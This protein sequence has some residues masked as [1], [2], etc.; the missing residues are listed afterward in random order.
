MAEEV[1]ELTKKLAE[2]WEVP[3]PKSWR[4]VA[5]IFGLSEEEARRRRIDWDEAWA[6]K[7]R[8]LLPE[9]LRYS[10]LEPHLKELSP[11]EVGA[12]MEFFNPKTRMMILKKRG[13]LGDKLAREILETFL[14]GDPT[15]PSGTVAN[16]GFIEWWRSI[17]EDPWE[18]LREL[19]YTPKEIEEK[20]G[21]K[22]KA[23]E[24]LEVERVK[25]EELE[26]KLEEIKK[27]ERM[28]KE[29]EEKIRMLK[30]EAGLE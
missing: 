8:N 2:W 29:L 30:K 26:P 1:S 11:E 7:V 25:R 28:K 4:E 19:G 22:P 3:P 20:F 5:E 15:A 24:M 10:R 18:K 21:V 13:D 27:L 17:G 16:M 23:A 9:F 12:V 6:A 14:K